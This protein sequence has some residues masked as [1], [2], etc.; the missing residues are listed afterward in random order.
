MVLDLM[1]NDKEL[2]DLIMS[3]ISGVH[4]TPVGDNKFKST[5]KSDNYTGFPTG[6]LTH[7]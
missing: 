4:Y 6:A 7:L 3:G 1:Q 5:D 2:H